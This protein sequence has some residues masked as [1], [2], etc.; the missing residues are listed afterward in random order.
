MLLAVD[1][2]GHETVCLGA[3]MRVLGIENLLSAKD[4]AIPRH[5]D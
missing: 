1:L 3:E 5:T 2:L 4:V